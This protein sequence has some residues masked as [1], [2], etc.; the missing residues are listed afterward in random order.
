[1]A[2]GPQAVARERVAQ[3]AQGV[4]G[5]PLR[6]RGIDDLGAEHLTAE[7]R[8]GLGLLRAQAVVHVQ[9]RDA[10][11]E[12]AQHVP[13]TGRVGPARDERDDLAARRDQVVPPDV[14]LDADEQVHGDSVA[15]RAAQKISERYAP[16]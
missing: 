16:T 11:A 5:R 4:L 6:R 8:V 9:R 7:A 13:E 3:L 12:R 1:M 14:L 2:G 10:V 15:A